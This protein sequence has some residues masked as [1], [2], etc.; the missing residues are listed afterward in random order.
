MSEENTEYQVRDEAPHDHFCQIPN[1][2]D[3]MHLSPHT[4]R[5]YGHLRRV[6]GENGKCW[7][8]TET[9]ADACNMSMGQVS[10]SKAELET[11]NPPLIRIT[12]KRK[13]DGG[14][15]HEIYIIDIWAF[16]HDF[17]QKEPLHTVKGLTPSPGE[18]TPSHSETKKNSIK[19]NS[20]PGSFEPSTIEQA[21]YAGLPVTAEML[22]G[23]KQKHDRMI[24]S[25]NLIDTGCAGAGGI[26]LAFQEE[27]GIVILESQ[28]K[29]QRTAA[30]EMMKQG[31]TPEHIREAV[32]S[33]TQ[34][35]MTVTDLYSVS[36]TAVSIANPAPETGNNPQGLS[37]E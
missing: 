7:Q 34:K 3:D 1:I 28:V 32:R 35:G 30:R 5:L 4:Y 29:G 19:N 17:Y 37:I 14:I 26:A 31:V 13:T 27:R 24:D 22:D 11:S 16:N 2:V 36:K 33:L 21:V 6:A 15:Y 25:A 23:N 12:S 8:N 9:L 20:I 10:K 18:R